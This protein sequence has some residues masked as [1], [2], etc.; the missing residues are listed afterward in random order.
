MLRQLDLSVFELKYGIQVRLVT[1]E[2]A[3]FIVKLRT[4]PQLNKFLNATDGSI[5][6]QKNWIREYKKREA[7]AEDFY[8]LY[9]KDG[10][11]FGVNRIYDI[12]TDRATGGSWICKRGLSVD[13]PVISLVIMRE[14]MFE[15]LQLNFDYFDVRKQNKKVVKVHL[16][17]GAQKI[18]ET[19][20]D[21]Y[22]VLS[23]EEFYKNKDYILELLNY[24]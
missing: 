8:L 22:Y 21:Y 10:E 15:Q 14:I 1:E 23:K 9:A 20:L 7:K 17:F 18:D 19:D 12:Q 4:D 13:L 24:K 6:K 2:D 11:V 16:M 3:E 5:E